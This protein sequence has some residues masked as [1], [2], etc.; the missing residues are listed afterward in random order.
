MPHVMMVL[1]K[2]Y[3]SCHK[4]VLF[5][6]HRE[7]VRAPNI[8]YNRKALRHRLQEWIPVLHSALDSCNE[9]PPP[10]QS[11]SLCLKNWLNETSY[12]DV[13]MLSQM[14]L[15]TG[16]YGE[17]EG[18]AR[19]QRECSRD[20]SVLVRKEVEERLHG[21]KESS[22]DST[23]HKVKK[24]DE[25][26]SCH[27]DSTTDTMTRDQEMCARD[28][29]TLEEPSRDKESLR[30]CE[31]ITS[32]NELSGVGH[33]VDV[34]GSREASQE[35]DNEQRSSKSASLPT[36]YDHYIKEESE[37]T[38]ESCSQNHDSFLKHMSPVCHVTNED[39]VE[40]KR[41]WDRA[42]FMRRY[43]ELLRVKDIRHTLGVTTGYKHASWS[44]LLQCIRGLYVQIV[45]QK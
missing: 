32:D 4:T 44:I 22:L 34:E 36:T 9:S 16:V 25:S 39:E 37:W 7:E 6:F 30:N 13:C 27:G 41:D 8:L 14:C 20:N 31:V 12:D 5:L 33:P 35:E 28:L 23:D 26:S 11:A 42:C 24:E 10:S 15:D 45:S 19:D 43:F 18:R 38:C 3:Y 2:K 21:E 40:K 17:T 29:K 1:E